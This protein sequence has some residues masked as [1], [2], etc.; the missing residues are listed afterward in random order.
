MCNFQPI[1]VVDRAS[2]TQPQLVKNLNKITYG[3]T[4]ETALLSVNRH[5][6]LINIH[7]SQVVFLINLHEV[8]HSNFKHDKLDRN[9]S[10]RHRPNAGLY[11]G[12]LSMMLAQH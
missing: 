1:E 5:N 8:C 10:T 7:L 11:L 12:P 2:E 3:I 4:V 9:T 6:T